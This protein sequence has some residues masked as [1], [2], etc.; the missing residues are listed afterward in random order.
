MKVVVVV[1]ARNAESLLVDCVAAILRQT[2]P[3]DEVLLVIG[4]SADGTAALAKGI[5]GPTVRVLDNPAGDRGSALNVAL[6]S[7][8]ADVLAFVDAQAR[9]APDY[10][11]QAVAALRVTDAAAVGGPMRPLGRTTTGRAMAMALQTGFGSGGSQFHFAGEGREVES[12]YLGVYRADVFARV[13]WYNPALLRTED[14]DLNWRLRADGLKIWLDPAISSTYLCRDSLGGVWSQYHG[15]GR[16]KVALA[17]L[18]PGAIRLRHLVPAAFVLAL[19][20]AALAS[21]AWWWPALPLLLAAYLVAAGLAAMRAPGTGLGARFLYPV[22]TLTMHLAYGIGSLQGLI[23]WFGL[24]RRARRGE[25]LA[26]EAQQ[27]AGDSRSADLERIRQTYQRYDDEDRAR[28]WDARNPGYARMVADRE[29]RLVALLEESLPASGGAVLDLGCGTGDL[30]ESARSGGI[31]AAWTGVDLR[32]EAIAHAAATYP[33]ATFVEAS[34]DALPFADASFDVVV[35]STLFSSLPS[36]TLERAVAAEISRVLRAGGWLV[37]YDLRYDNPRN[38][39][40]HGLDARRL[41]ELFPGWAMD[42]ASVTLLPPLARHLG[43]ATRVL[44]PALHLIPALRSHLI[45][46]ARQPDAQ[47]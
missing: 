18:R 9:I 16:W 19:V 23:G 44:Y 2:R 10:L 42:L 4:P 3:A 28:L 37:W 40:V 31:A 32:S 24:R 11:E 39:A 21:V 7:T 41:R 38:P 8:D 26:A 34:G 14:D 12:V 15:Y 6:A 35:V 47:E 33:W 46:R 30:A 45:G 20:A 13:G 43:P 29:R 27:A 25:Q 17:T 36:A 22:V 1:P 5:A